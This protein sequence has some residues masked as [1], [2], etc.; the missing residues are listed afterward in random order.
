MAR[1][2]AFP[3]MARSY[4]RDKNGRFSGSGGG[5]KIAKSD[6][7]ETAR[8]KYKKAAGEAREASKSMAKREKRGTVDAFAKA[9]SKRTKSN[10]TRVTNQLTGKKGGK[11]AVAK[12]AP[13]QSKGLASARS[14]GRAKGKAIAAK[15][16]ARN[17]ALDRKAKA[18][19]G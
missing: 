14:S 5:G 1:E 15:V 12:K 11:K 7:N 9:E 16:S 19:G 13:A 4:K 17:A 6:K 2:F 3:A 8:A 10:L 18:Y